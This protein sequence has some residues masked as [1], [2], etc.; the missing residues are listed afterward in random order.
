MKR[1]LRKFIFPLLAIA[2][3]TPWPVAYAYAN[4]SG[5]AAA[6]AVQIAAAAPEAAPSWRSFGGTVGGVNTPGDLFYID[7]SNSAA[8]IAVSLYLT[9]AADLAHHYRYL[10]LKVGVYLRAGTDQWQE[11][12]LPDGT[13]LPASYITMRSGRVE[14]TLPGYASYKLSIDGG[15][16]YRYQSSAGGGSASPEFYLAVE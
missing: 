1:K 7:A 13:A 9:N 2:L 12:V 8:D 4:A 6:A 14:L 3:L 15:S 5:A 10:I 11:A 16:F